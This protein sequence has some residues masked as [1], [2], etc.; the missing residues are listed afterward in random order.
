MREIQAF[1]KSCNSWLL[2]DVSFGREIEF[3]RQNTPP[4]ESHARAQEE[5]AECVS[6]ANRRAEMQ[7]WELIRN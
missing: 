2:E 6:D 7:A 4:D 5:L 1:L 3:I